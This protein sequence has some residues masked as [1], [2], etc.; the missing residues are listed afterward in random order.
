V[1]A[2]Y[3]V[4]LLSSYRNGPF[5]WFFRIHHQSSHLGDEFILNSSAPVN[6]LNL[7]FEEIDLKLSYELTGWLR[8]YGG[9]GVL[10]GRGDP[11]TLGRGTSQFGAELTSPWTLLSGTIRPVLYADFQAN[12]RSS[13]V[14]G[15]SLM[16]GLQFE[17]ARI[18]DRKV[19]LLAE[20]FKGPSPNGQ[21]FSQN[22]DWIGLG[23]HLYY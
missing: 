9:G 22:T 2:D 13:W 3:T 14:V 5:S 8:V 11:T 20:Y 4:G 17:N 23:L 12:E 10:V 6:R 7:S 21:F 19:Q 18:G 1:N 15:S 16:A